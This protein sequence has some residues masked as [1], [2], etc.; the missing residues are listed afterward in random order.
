M[1]LY[2]DP[3]RPWAPNPRRVS[4][5][6][7][8]KRI[9]VP[10]VPVSMDR[11]EHKAI[12]FLAKN[13]LGQLPILELPTGEVICESTSICRYIEQSAGHSGPA[14][15]GGAADQQARIDMWIRR[16]EL[17][18]WAPVVHVWRNDDPR[19]ERMVTPRF[20]NFGRFNRDVAGEAMQ[21]LDRELGAGGARYVAGDAFSMADIILVCSIDFAQRLGIERPASTPW[22]SEWHR[23]VMG[24]HAIY[25]PHRE[26]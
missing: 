6:L 10:I 25:A 18:L 21:W 7:A 24:R 20:E 15:F 16:I 12:E 8:E 22:L 11:R 5:F 17:R 2:L 26:G 23:T 19:T 14:L 1:K 9:V 13:S 3:A 4:I